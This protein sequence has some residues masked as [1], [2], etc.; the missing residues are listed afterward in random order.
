M[1]LE[2]S[3]LS[4]ERYHYATYQI[5]AF[6]AAAAGG[7]LAAEEHGWGAVEMTPKKLPPMAPFSTA[8]QLLYL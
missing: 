7:A 1:T 8:R 4:F 5:H 3:W 6:P 2:E